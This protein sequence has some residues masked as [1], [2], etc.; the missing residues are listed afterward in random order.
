[1]IKAREGAGRQMLSQM[2]KDGKVKNLGRVRYVHP[3]FQ[4][5]V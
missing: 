2:V 4:E 1:M 3:S 5:D